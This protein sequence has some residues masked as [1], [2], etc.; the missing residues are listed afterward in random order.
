VFLRK[1]RIKLRKKIESM[2]FIE[3]KCRNIVKKRVAEF[4]FETNISENIHF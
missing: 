2:D 1:I 3:K 4:S